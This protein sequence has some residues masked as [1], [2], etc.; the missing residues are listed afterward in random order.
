M[1][2]LDPYISIVSTTL[3]F[4]NVP[5][6]LTFQVIFVSAYYKWFVLIAVSSTIME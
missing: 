4:D 6:I 1:I 3:E 5:D 2:V